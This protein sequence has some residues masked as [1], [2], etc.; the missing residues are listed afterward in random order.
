MARNYEYKEV[1]IADLILDDENPRFASSVLVQDSAAKVS[2]TAII[3]HLL[4]YADI[5]KLA[6]RI[7]NVQE[8]HGSEVITCYKRNDDYVVLEGNRRICACKLL[9]NRSLIP[10]DYKSNFPFLK[11][12]TKDNIERILV[13]VYPNR[14]AVQAF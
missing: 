10:D 6:N 13:I 2:Q 14:E 11:D 8:L 4:K 12:E 1:N 5:I 9:L 3:N 7:N